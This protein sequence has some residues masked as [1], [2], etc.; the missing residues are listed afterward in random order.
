VHHFLEGRI[1]NDQLACESDVRLCSPSSSSNMGDQVGTRAQL[2]VD[3]CLARPLPLIFQ[4]GRG[5]SE[6]NIAE[7]YGF[8]RGRHRE[9]Q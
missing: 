2:C 1:I 3:G 4:E 5:G 6:W 8:V 7:R 9:R